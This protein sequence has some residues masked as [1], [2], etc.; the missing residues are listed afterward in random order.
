MLKRIIYITLFVITLVLLA[1]SVILKS[2]LKKYKLEK[3]VSFSVVLPTLSKTSGIAF[4]FYNTKI[5]IQ[6][7]ITDPP[8]TL[9]SNTVTI[10]PSWNT[11]F[12]N[13]KIL[14]LNST[15]FYDQ[16]ELLTEGRIEADYNKG[17]LQTKVA[18]SL[19]EIFQSPINFEVIIDDL[20]DSF[21]GHCLVKIPDLNIK[22][23][24]FSFPQLLFNFN[25]KEIWWPSQSTATINEAHLI[26][27]GSLDLH[28]KKLSFNFKTDT[29]KTQKFTLTED[30]IDTTYTGEGHGYFQFSN[31]TPQYLV[32][33]KFK[34]LNGEFL[35][36]NPEAIRKNRALLNNILSVLKIKK[37]DKSSTFIFNESQIDLEISNNRF[38]FKKIQL[39][40]KSNTLHTKGYYTFDDQYKFKVRYYEAASPTPLSFTIKGNG[41]NYKISPNPIDI[42]NAIPDLILPTF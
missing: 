31:G 16:K 29:L 19:N 41:D 34:S 35:L 12:T 22:T 1:P 24:N 7:N 32:N 27:E 33:S 13:Y 2:I 30:L 23:Y 20:R 3:E 5:S 6:K 28:S 10:T 17:K 15:I 38:N 25:R 11:Q 9:T 8:I 14:A 37:R 26:S 21:N 40:K 39:N 42:I 36:F 18:T 4:H